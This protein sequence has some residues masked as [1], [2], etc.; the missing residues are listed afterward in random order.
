MGAVNHFEAGAFIR[1]KKGIKFPDIQHHFFPGAVEQ[2]KDVIKVH[3]YQVHC[4]TMRPKSRGF[5]QLQSDNPRDKP[6]IQPNLLQEKEDLDDLCDGV[7]LTIEILNAKAFKK[8]RKGAINFDPKMATNRKQLEDW[9]KQHVESAYHC[10]CTC[11]MGEVTEQDGR[12]KGIENL[13]VV[14]ASIMPSVVSGN[15]NAPTIMMAEKI[16]D[17]IKGEKLSTPDVKFYVHKNWET[18]QR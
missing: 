6:I 10:S 18:H 8:Y 13:R 12:V 3:A 11:A 1:S 2:Q 9:V 4:G 16:A 5:I 14:D 17:M 15:T 7:E